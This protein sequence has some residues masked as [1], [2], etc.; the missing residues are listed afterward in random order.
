[1]KFIIPISFL[2]SICLGDLTYEPDFDET[3]NNSNWVTT[4]P[5][6]RPNKLNETINKPL[7]HFA[8]SSGWMNDPN[9]CFKN[10]KTGEWNLYY[11]YCGLKTVCVH[12]CSG[13][14]LFPMI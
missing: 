7:F 1:M 6:L 9:G 3:L 2:I 4:Y 14:M 11:Q 8:P 13:V 5:K 12:L 10:P